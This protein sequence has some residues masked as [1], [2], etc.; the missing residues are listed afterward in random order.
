[1]R[2]A[3]LDPRELE[4]WLEALRDVA[5][6]SKG[7]GDMLLRALDDE[8]TSLGLLRSGQ[9]VTRYLN[10]IDKAEE[11]AYPGDLAIEKRIRALL[12]W[13]AV[14][15]VM[16]AN[17][18]DVGVGGHLSTYASAASLLE[19]GF[20]HFFRGHDGSVSD[21]VFFQ[22][23]SAPG[24]Y[25]R[26]FLEGRL[27]AE[28]LDR[29]RSELVGDGLA[30]Y[31]H[32]RTM[33][34]FWEFS[35]VSMGL[36]PLAAIHQAH[37]NKYLEA[38]GLVADAG[39]VWCF[40]G[41]GEMDEPETTAAIRLA[42]RE[43]LDNLIFVVNCNLQ[44]LDGPVRGNGK[45]INE[46]E[47]L[48]RGAGWQVFKVLWGA[49]WDALL[50]KDVDGVLAAKLEATVDGEFQRLVTL[51]G[52]QIREQF[53]GSDPRLAEL[54][55]DLDDE[56]LALLPRGGH[57]STKI[58]AAYEAAV[59]E[60]GRPSVVLAHTVKGWALGGKVEGRN[61]THQMKKLDTEAL[62]AMAERLGISDLVRLEDFDDGMP[63][64]LSLEQSSP[65]AAYLAEK[66]RV[67]GGAVPRREVA[68]QGLE[69]ADR[70]VLDEMLAGSGSAS[71]STTMAFVRALRGLM[72]DPVIGQRVVPIVSD[73]AR[74]FG[75]EPLISEMA[76]YDPA[77]M[78]YESVDAKLPLS[79]KES[80]TGRIFE[81]GISEAGAMASFLG[82]GSSYATHGLAMLPVFSFY[83]M[84]G[85]QRVG[86]IA[87][88]AADMR[89]RGILA[90]CTAGRTTL[91]GEGL[92]HADGHSLL[93]ASSNPAVRAYDPS[94]AYELAVLVDEAVRAGL[95]DP[96]ADLLWYFTLY[97]ENWVMPAAPAQMDY[98][99]LREAVLGGLYRR[100]GDR[101]PGEMLSLVASGP[102][103]AIITEAAEL[104]AHDWGIACDLWSA[105]SWG[106]LRR[107][108]IEVERWNRL[109]PGAERRRS[110]ADELLGEGA[111]VVVVSDH[112]RA[113]ADS[114]AASS[115]R[116]WTVLGTDGFGLSDQRSRMRS[117]FEVD[118][119][120]VVLASLAALASHGEI[121]QSV[122][123]AALERYGI[124]PEAAGPLSV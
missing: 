102:M 43:K 19:V 99:Q 120:H 38:H 4:E 31:P 61:A 56:E 70:S 85:F 68:Y 106:E 62:L 24:I 91:E 53:F 58:Y 16:R 39:R 47:G 5:A 114:V 36:G 89:V 11:P 74:T 40:V 54:V 7:A 67:L 115:R 57:D 71:V 111:P 23:H 9:L 83:S 49:K 6:R 104:L 96:G 8:A 1:M 80:A 75:M 48:F 10:S 64:Y 34:E 86:D 65:E 46:F 124:D 29:Y 100:E 60:E 81:E 2:D 27:S 17:H 55:A 59:R 69:L 26:A 118:A 15:M 45:V 112:M 113:L 30:S 82:L 78:R 87:W 14:A 51:D 116:D 50:T 122:V 73:E 20:N 18:R 77:G 90:G 32:P 123:R 35:T 117:Y 107:D 25:A 76:I 63:P 101:A 103:H 21:Q 121:D 41:D 98:E 109:H 72:R 105:T 108:A 92:Q 110:R 22:G 33:E 93:L 52:A 97:N 95:G 94:F 28:Q 37:V 13:N 66:R 12:R 79:Y 42:A 88:Q 3:D 119:P 84:F 44:R